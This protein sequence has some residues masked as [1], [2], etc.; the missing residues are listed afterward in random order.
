MDK[1]KKNPLTETGASRRRFIKTS[2]SAAAGLAVLGGLGSAP[3]LAQ[4]RT[5]KIGYVS[6]QTGPLAGFAEADEYILSAVR[7]QLAQGLNIRGNSHPV[8]I[9]VRDSQ[10]NPNRA[11]EVASDLILGEDVDL[12]LVASTP[13]TTNPV[14]DQCEIMEVPCI[15]TV[16]PWQPW[17]FTRGGAPDTGFRWTY[18][19]FWGLEDLMANYTNMWNQLDTNKVVGG[20]F[21]NDGDGNAWGQAFPPELQ[22]QGYRIIDLGRYQN[23]SDDFSSQIGAFRDARADIV[24]G[25]MIPP[26]LTTFWTQARQ[27]GFRPK[28]ASI[29][30]A[31]LFPSA[32]EALGDAGH[33]LSSEI[34]WTPSHPF[35][36]SL[37]GQSS[38]ELAMGYTQATGR[39]WTQ[40]I[41]FVHALFEV[42]V[43]VLSRTADAGDRNATMDAIRGTELDSI[44]GPI[45][46]KDS[47]IANVSKTP[48]VAGQWRLGGE[49][50]Y[51]LVITENRLAPMVPRQDVM[52][53]LT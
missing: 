52:Q 25:V 47:P 44:V 11:A 12:M 40:P 4:N 43:D 1:Y 23:L 16:A 18:H 33:N 49:F 15:S 20:M 38:S 6:P 2:G 53:P 17:M 46:W 27:Q 13:E 31:I 51:E 32:V 50:R 21:P 30:K 3:A 29:G 34:W 9:L 8:E 36:S 24:T 26:D 39:Q 48:L 28:A 19:F 5:L 42:A 45:N 37:T 41:G 10:S 7:E 35:N 14:A 22:S